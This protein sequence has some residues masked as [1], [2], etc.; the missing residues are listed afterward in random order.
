MIEY[1]PSLFRQGDHFKC[2]VCGKPHRKLSVFFYRTDKLHKIDVPIFC[3]EECIDETGIFCRALKPDEGKFLNDM[4]EGVL[5]KIRSRGILGRG[6]EKY[7]QA[8][9]KISGW[10][11]YT[12]DHESGIELHLYYYFMD[13]PKSGDEL[14]NYVIEKINQN[15]L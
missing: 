3:S 7:G 6:W 8:L 13:N 15:N 1:S 4:Y 9:G 11:E 12:I 14:R 5:P 2:I 10:R